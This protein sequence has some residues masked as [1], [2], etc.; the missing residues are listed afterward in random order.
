MTSIVWRW[1]N[2]N[3]RVVHSLFNWTLLYNFKCIEIFP[4]PLTIYREPFRAQNIGL[5]NRALYLREVED[6]VPCFVS[7]APMH[8]HTSHYIAQTAQ[9]HNLLMLSQVTWI[10]LRYRTIGLSRK[11][12]M[13][14]IGKDRSVLVFPIWEAPILLTFRDADYH[15]R[16]LVHMILDFQNDFLFRVMIE[17]IPFLEVVSISIIVKS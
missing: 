3:G 8:A 6:L 4:Y 9:L 2:H 1:L 15:P 12:I 5:K 11:E 14:L 7:W 13:I 16:P 17:A 10:K